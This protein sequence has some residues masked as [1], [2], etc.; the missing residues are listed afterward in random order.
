LPGIWIAGSIRTSVMNLTFEDWDC[1]IEEVNSHGTT[2][3]GNTSIGS[4]TFYKSRDST[5]IV[6][7]GNKR[8]KSRYTQMHLLT[9]AV[10]EAMY[11]KARR[12]TNVRF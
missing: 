1:G 12:R 11:E 9:Y 2:V 6:A 10:R 4:G 7:T 3:V 8:I 5:G